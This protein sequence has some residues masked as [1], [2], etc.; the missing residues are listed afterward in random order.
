VRR[1]GA[2]AVSHD[3]SIAAHGK[4]TGSSYRPNWLHSDKHPQSS[5]SAAHRSPGQRWSWYVNLVSGRRIL[6]QWVQTR[7]KQNTAPGI[8]R[9]SAGFNREALYFNPAYDPI[10][11]IGLSF[12]NWPLELSVSRIAICGLITLPVASSDLTDP[13]NSLVNR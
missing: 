11:A 4:A 13:V 8:A 2:S 5:L 12:Q 1:P 10:A 3:D 9:G 6:C 7:C